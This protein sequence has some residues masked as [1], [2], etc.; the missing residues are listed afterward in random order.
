VPDEAPPDDELL[1]IREANRRRPGIGTF[2]LGLAVFAVIAFPLIAVITS[3]FGDR[4][5]LARY[6]ME[7]TAGSLF[8]GIAAAVWACKS[9]TRWRGRRI[10][11]EKPTPPLR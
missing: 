5:E 2:L 4:K 7:L 9:L 6:T 1:R 10:D 3:V 8:A 11:R